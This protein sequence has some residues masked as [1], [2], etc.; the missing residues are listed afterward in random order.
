MQNKSYNSTYSIIKYTWK[1]DA[2]PLSHANTVI[3]LTTIFWP[4]NLVDILGKLIK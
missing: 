3:L 1:G 4:T 2:T